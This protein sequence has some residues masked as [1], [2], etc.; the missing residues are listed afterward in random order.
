MYVILSPSFI[1]ICCYNN[2]YINFKKVDTATLLAVILQIVGGN[3]HHLS[4]KQ[5]ILN[6]SLEIS[7]LYE[8]KM[9]LNTQ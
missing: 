2:I 6:F 7:E 9:L 3:L 5:G 8:K 4:K 1:V